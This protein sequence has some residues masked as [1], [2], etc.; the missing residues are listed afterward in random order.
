MFKKIQT[1]NLLIFFYFFFYIFSSVSLTKETVPFNNI[2]QHK[3]PKLISPIMFEDFNGNKLNLEDYSGK[4]II[5][6]F[7]ATWCKPCKEEMPSLDALSQNLDFKNLIIFPINVE[8]TN[9]KKTK[10][11][12]SNLNIQKLKIFFD[13]ELNFVK[14]L[15]L[16]G[17]P[18]TILINKQR[19]EFARIIG[20]IDFMDSEFLD[21]LSNYD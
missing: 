4:L 10:D 13:S 1:I 19:K 12:F 2:A 18:T 16:R 17:V 6:N 20:T 8:G 3:S 7:W 11:F 15:K 21:W 5:I 9:H 14:E